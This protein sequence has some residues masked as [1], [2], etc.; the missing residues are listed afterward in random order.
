MYARHYYGD[1]PAWIEE[2][3]LERRGD[4][5]LLL[6]PDVPWVADGLQR[7][8]PVERDLLHGLFRSALAGLGARVVAISGT[9]EERRERAFAAI[10]AAIRAAPGPV[11]R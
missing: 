2:A 3:A 1:C 5:Y 8:R 6:H 11:S 10:R 9:W 7:D 4:L